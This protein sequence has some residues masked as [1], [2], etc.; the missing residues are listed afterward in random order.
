MGAALTVVGRARAVWVLRQL[1]EIK[2]HSKEKSG[3]TGSSLDDWM[4]SNS[5][6]NINSEPRER[7]SFLGKEDRSG[8]EYVEFVLMVRHLVK[9]THWTIRNVNPGL[10][11]KFGAG[12][13]G[14]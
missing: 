2:G 1:P 5:A 13:V 4:K 9:G 7:T 3:R 6:L 8:L 14:V 11:R 10:R 12:N